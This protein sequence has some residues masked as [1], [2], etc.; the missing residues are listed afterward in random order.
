MRL[1]RTALAISLAF[2]IAPACAQEAE[3]AQDQAQTETAVTAA[4]AETADAA[5]GAPADDAMMTPIPAA[6]PDAATLGDADAPVTIVEYAST[7][8]PHC[9]NFHATLFPHIKS[10]WI[11]TGRA[12]LVMR[13]LPTAPAQLAVASFLVATCAGEGEAYFDALGD[14]FATQEELFAAAQG[15]DLQAYYDGVGARHGVTPAELEQCLGDENALAGIQASIDAAVADMIQGTP[16]FVI[17]GVT[18]Q[19]GELPDTAS[20]DAT[21]QAALDAQ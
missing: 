19:A 4:P 18:Y 8:C 16:G 2:A 1:I 14:L 6:S 10:Q 15:G 7:T 11:D 21:L 13:P 17:N 5:P 12:K 20:W 9:A 3:D